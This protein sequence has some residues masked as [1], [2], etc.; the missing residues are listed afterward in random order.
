[1][2]FKRNDITEVLK[3]GVILFAITAIAAAILAGVNGVTAPVIAENNKKAQEAAIR[4]VLPDAREIKELEYEATQGS[5]VTGIY[6][7]GDAGYAVKA[8]PNGYGGAIEMIIGIG[9]DNVVAGIEIISQSET[10]GLGSKCTTDEFK[11]Q[12]TGKRE[13]IT[14]VKGGGAKG[15]EIDAISSATVTSK[16]VT[17]GVNDAIA[18][19]LELKGGE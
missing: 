6:S 9:A 11:N 1:M 15:N 4:K 18:A 13:G 17:R 12:F 7:G 5:S 8:V 16:A 14:V 19:V 3:V 2:M 10:A